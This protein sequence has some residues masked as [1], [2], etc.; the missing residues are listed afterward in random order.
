M[1]GLVVRGVICVLHATKGAQG[2]RATMV[3]FV[4]CGW[5]NVV[6]RRRNLKHQSTVV[7]LS[8]ETASNRVGGTFLLLLQD[9]SQIGYIDQIPD[10]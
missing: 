7:R 5:Y 6:V 8:S 4:F 3:C 1:R 2:F 10:T 9:V